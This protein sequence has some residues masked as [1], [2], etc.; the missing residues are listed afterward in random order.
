MERC[1][2]PL[3]TLPAPGRAAPGQPGSFRD[4]WRDA[5]ADPGRGRGGGG[6]R[7]RAV[8]SAC[9]SGGCF[10]LP[11]P[12]V[13]RTS[14][15]LVLDICLLPILIRRHGTPTAP[16]ASQPAPDPT[17][18]LARARSRRALRRA[19]AAAAPARAAAPRLRADRAPAGGGGRG[20]ANRRRQPLPAAARARGGGRGG[21]AGDAKAF[22]P[23]AATRCG[24]AFAILAAPHFTGLAKWARSAHFL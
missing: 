8:A 9:R 24:G 6:R 13:V 21:D 22:P 17:G 10:S 5:G 16:P 20:D 15:S 7:V 19:G 11:A 3:L 23:P 4:L 14:W 12:P 2:D 18:P 1:A